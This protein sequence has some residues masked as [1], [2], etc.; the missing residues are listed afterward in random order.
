MKMHSFG[1]VI[2]AAMLVLATS[3]GMAA[4]MAFSGNESNTTA[5]PMPSASCLPSQVQVKIGAGDNAV[6][7]SNFGSFATTQSH[8]IALPLPANYG[9]GLFSYAFAQGDVLMGTYF[10]S[11][12]ASD[13]AG[14]FDNVQ[15]FTATGGTGRFLGSSGGFVGIGTLDLRPGANIFS[16][17]QFEGLLNLPAVPEPTTWAMLITGFGLTGAVLRRR[18]AIQPDRS[19]Q[20]IGL[21]AFRKSR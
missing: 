6:G 8:C 1:A 14:V 16:Q 17:L 2:A 21:K 9:D 19:R 3:P 12:T 13:V 11:L 18:R 4:I 15:Y 7:S 10:G 5:P 20:D